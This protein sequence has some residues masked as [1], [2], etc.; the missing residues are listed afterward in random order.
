MV[1]DS[2]EVAIQK[3]SPVDMSDDSDSQ[4]RHIIIMTS[5]IR[6]KGPLKKYVTLFWLI[7]EPL[8]PPCDIGLYPAPF[9]VTFFIKT[10]FTRLRLN[11]I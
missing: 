3:Q 8:P 10:S 11:F 1:V 5:E 7:L 2:D 4:V 9:R 6:H